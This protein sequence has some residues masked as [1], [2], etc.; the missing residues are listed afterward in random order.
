MPIRRS[1][2]T[3]DELRSLLEAGRRAELTYFPVGLSTAA[4]PPPGY[5]LDRWERPLGRGDD[6]FAR[7][8]HALREWRVH[9]GAGL[10][11]CA[12][13]PPTVGLVVAMSAPLPVGFID[14]TCRIVSV[15]DA[16]GRFGFAYGTLPVHPQRGEESFSVERDDDGEVTF[17]IVAASRPHHPLAR[18][19]PPVTRRL[20]RAGIERYLDAMATA[21]S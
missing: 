3:T 5:R 4:E 13:G 15:V 8:V 14:V 18:L 2:P 17:R 6:V 9:R 19:C 21:V 20:Q 10:A 7:A 12:D 11:V 16:P 1:R